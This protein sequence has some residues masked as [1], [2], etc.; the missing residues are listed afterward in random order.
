MP[1]PLG[2]EE[3]SHPAYIIPEDVKVPTDSG[4]EC[5]SAP[6]VYPRHPEVPGF[7][8]ISSCFFVLEGLIDLTDPASD[9]IDTFLKR[10]YDHTLLPSANGSDVT[11]DTS[12]DT[13]ALPQKNVMITSK[14]LLL[15]VYE[16]EI[17]FSGFSC[18]IP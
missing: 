7:L 13:T 2:R 11:P 17:S 8:L 1:Q 12:V 6:S 4:S 5:C 14:C 16:I 10:N 15:N 3:Y 9:P 18:T